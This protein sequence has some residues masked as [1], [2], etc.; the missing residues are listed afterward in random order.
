MNSA[1]LVLCLLLFHSLVPIGPT[2]P[3][4]SATLAPNDGI[5]G[6]GGAP[7]RLDCGTSQVQKHRRVGEP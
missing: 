1:R 7:F 4:S 3:S 2:V 6:D 5:G